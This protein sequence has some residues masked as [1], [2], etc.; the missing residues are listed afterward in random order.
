MVTTITIDLRDTPVIYDTILN[1]ANFCPNLEVACW[2][3]DSPPPRASLSKSSPQ[4]FDLAHEGY[5]PC[6]FGVLA[7]SICHEHRR[8]KKLLA[9]PTSTPNFL[10]RL[11]PGGLHRVSIGYV[12]HSHLHEH[13]Y[14]LHGD[15]CGTP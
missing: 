14:V 6:P 12:I 13:C 11:V 10:A 3:T 7:P 5:P 2:T 1:P 15:F 8:T 4:H 9:Y